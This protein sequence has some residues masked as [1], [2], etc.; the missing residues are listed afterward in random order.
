MKYFLK[1]IFQNGLLDANGKPFPFE[2][3]GGNNGV[4]AIDETTP[5]GQDLVNQLTALHRARIG[6]IVPMTE[7]EY[8][9]KKAAYP[10]EQSAP[11]S[12]PLRVLQVQRPLTNP[13]N[14][15][16][17][18]GDGKPVAPWTPPQTPAAQA[19]TQPP[20]PAPE[21][22]PRRGKIPTNAAEKAALLEKSKAE[23]AVTK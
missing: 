2:P 1:E 11:M 13:K 12:T 20:P 16:V 22:I 3:I 8:S 14:A 7:G 4:A 5:A 6:G 15:P 23:A 21:F 9:A 19:P 10:L 17:V 18:E